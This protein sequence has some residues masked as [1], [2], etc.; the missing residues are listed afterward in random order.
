MRLLKKVARWVD[1]DLSKGPRVARQSDD[2]IAVRGLAERPGLVFLPIVLP[3]FTV[4]AAQGFPQS[5]PSGT[6][7]LVALAMTSLSIAFIGWR[8]LRLLKAK[9]LKSG[10]R[11]ERKDRYFLPPD[12]QDTTDSALK[13]SWRRKN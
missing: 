12:Y 3:V 2:H 4:A 6:S 11:Y 1:S 5:G 8:G 13:R 10:R 7:L 9:A